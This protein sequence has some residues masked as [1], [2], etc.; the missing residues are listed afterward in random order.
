[1]NAGRE[2]AWAER[3]GAHVEGSVGREAA[4]C[5][6]SEGDNVNEA[7]V[8]VAVDDG[9]KG[10]LDGFLALVVVTDDRNCP[11]EAGLGVVVMDVN[12]GMR[13]IAVAVAAQVGRHGEAHN[14][15]EEEHPVLDLVEGSCTVGVE[16]VVE[17]VEVVAG[18]LR[19]D[20]GARR[21]HDGSSLFCS[22]QNTVCRSPRSRVQD[23]H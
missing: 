20:V 11:V 4:T 22:V 19:S 3:H 12:V 10:S 2:W 6:E 21:I 15:E 18:Y 1:M 8:A 23:S 14:V 16:R 7:G 5:E 13:C 17:V 9:H